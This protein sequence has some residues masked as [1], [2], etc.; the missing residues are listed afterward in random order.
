MQYLTMESPVGPL[1]LAGSHAGLRLIGFSQGSMARTPD[2]DWS[3]VPTAFAD[4]QTQ[5]SEYFE[6]SRRT[7]DLTLDPAGTAFQ[8]AVWQAL[9]TIP[10]GETRSYLEVAKAV[11]KPK[12]VRAV[13]SANGR[14]PLPIV[15]PCH[16]VIGSDGS[17]TGF[18]GGLE[19]K[20]L[21]LALEQRQKVLF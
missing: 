15:V 8:Q 3:H 2:P 9:L 1:L 19:N 6:G 7:F 4:A 16:R 5:L 21:L 20:K 14:N 18:G 10:Y 11:G 12:A 13:G 17:L